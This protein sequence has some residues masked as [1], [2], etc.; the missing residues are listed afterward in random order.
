[1]SMG[2][3]PALKAT[4]EDNEHRT[5]QENDAKIAKLERDVPELRSMTGRSRSPRMQ[6]RQK[7]LTAARTP[8]AAIQQDSWKKETGKGAKNNKAST[9]L[10]A[11]VAAIRVQGV[12]D[13]Q[14]PICFNFQN[15]LCTDPTVCNRMFA[16]VA[17]RRA[18]CTMSVTA[19]SR[20]STEPRLSVLKALVR[21][22]RRQLSLSL[23]LFPVP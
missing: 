6:P 20:S 5:Q 10:G 14:Q 12:Q 23:L 9:Q 2:I 7:A 1:M 18:S 19:S 17:P 22:R 3:V 15:R 11:A 8:S 21:L 4:C 16:S 13:E